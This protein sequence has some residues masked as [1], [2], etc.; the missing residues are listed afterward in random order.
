MVIA[1][2]F[3]KRLLSDQSLDVAGPSFSAATAFSHFSE[4][5]GSSHPSF[6]KPDW[7]PSP[8]P[9]LVPFE[10]DDFCLEELR[11]VVNR[12]KAKSTPSPLDQVSYQIFKRCPSLVAALLDLFNCCWRASV[13]PAAWKMAVIKLLGKS[14]AAQDPSLPAKF[15][16]IALTSCVGKLFSSLLRHRWLSFMVD[17]KYLD[18]TCQKAFMPGIPGCVEHHCKLAGIVSDARKRHRSLAV[19]WLDLANAYGSVHHELIKFSLCH[20]HALP[21][22]QQIVGS[23]YSG[24]E[25]MVVT[26][27]WSTSLFPLNVGVYQGDPLSVVIFNTVIN[28]L[29]DTLHSRR[30]CGYS[31]PDTRHQVNALQFADDTCVVNTPAS[32]QHLLDLTD[33]WLQ[34]AGMQ[35]KPAKCSALAFSGSSAAMVD[36]LLHLGAD[37]LPFV[38]CGSVGLEDA[39]PLGCFSF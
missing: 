16:P 14:S 4:S 17:N 24:L 21:C 37:T 33:T 7:L 13:V 35:V 31:L 23:F 19:C 38:G 12:S 36:P 18:A 30:D 20:Y 8:V 34:W 25:G 5:Y 32:A 27:S 29:L 28:T 15:R 2:R 9:P 10:S 6:S 1:L 3:S 39:F 22:F 11:H 26:E